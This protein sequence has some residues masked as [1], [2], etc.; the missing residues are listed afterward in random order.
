MLPP[1]GVVMC[2]SSFAVALLVAAVGGAGAAA[3]D[4]GPQPELRVYGPGGPL[5]PVRGC[6]ERFAR[7][8]A[9]R[10]V[11]DGG[12]EERWWARAEKDADVVFEASEYMLTDLDRRHPGFLDGATRTSLWVR[13][14]GILVRRGNPKRIKGLEDLARPGVKL[15]DVNGSAQ[16]GLWEDL[17]GRLGLIPAIQRNIAVAVTN[18]SEAIAAWRTRP[19]L[20]AWITFTSWRDRL[21]DEA[22]AVELPEAQRLYRG[23]PVAATAR[24]TRR[25]LA[26][27]FIAFLGSEECH[28]VF[29]QA[30]WR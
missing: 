14:A 9:V 26:L 5:T 25:E 15:L 28:A 23:T 1:R 6:A 18:T 12:P 16:T 30:G 21:A 2:H 19:E 24:T 4:G 13:P 3:P 17:A 22:D 27:A 8:R 20:D 11:I 7:A 29:R 10:V